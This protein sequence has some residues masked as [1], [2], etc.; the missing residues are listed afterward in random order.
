MELKS[1]HVVQAAALAEA[2]QKK[3][4]RMRD[5][6]VPGL[7]IRI[8]GR[9]ASWHIMTR[10]QSIR[11]A[12]I[13][14]LS[15]KTARERARDVLNENRPPL[16]RAVAALLEAGIPPVDANL[17]AR[18]LPIDPQDKWVD[19][20][21][22]NDA[23]T[24]FL[25]QKLSEQSPRWFRQYKKH[26][27]DDAFFPVRFQPLAKLA[28]AKLDLIRQE[29]RQIYRPSKAKR[30]MAAAIDM[31]DW[32]WAEHRTEGG[33]DRL[34]FPWWRELTVKQPKS[35][36]RFVPSIDVLAKT[37]VVLRHTPGLKQVHVKIVEFIVATAQR[38]DQVCSL[39]RSQIER[40]PDGSGVIH[41]SNV[42]M[43]GGIPHAL[44]VPS[45]VLSH[46]ASE[47][48]YAFPADERG[49]RPVRSSVIN[50]WLGNLWGKRSTAQSEPYKGKPGP[51][52]GT[53]SL[54]PVLKETGIPFWTPHA[55]RSVL[56]TE[57][58]DA[59]LDAAASA[60]LSHKRI[61][62]VDLPERP[63][64]DVRAEDVTIRHYSR[65]QRLPLKKLGMEEWSARLAEAKKRAT[66]SLQ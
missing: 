2:G 19:T 3:E 49:D 8:R 56:A 11:L 54:S 50:R 65:A 39:E 4:I 22:W 35:S 26:A 47:G 15:L 17:I 18:G 45:E 60:I 9:T 24:R 43:K 40:N 37:V 63:S 33:L 59:M 44:W 66:A 7:C 12:A 13:D 48:R 52:R 16:K 58:I 6:L 21:T 32:V 20:W 64:G 29:S 34:N 30:V 53:G 27:E 23:M 55:V 5:A 14:E 62:T 1:A 42:Q 10:S 25:D 31:L 41:W 51:P 28:Y 61:G 36:K 46:V 57:L 38:I